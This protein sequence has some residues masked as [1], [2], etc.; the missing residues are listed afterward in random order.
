MRAR[1]IVGVAA[2][3]GVAALAVS[4]RGDGRQPAPLGPYRADWGPRYDPS[5]NRTAPLVRTGRTLDVTVRDGRCLTSDGRPE[6][7]IRGR[8]SH[9]AIRE[10]RDAV[11]IAVIMR[12][13]K[14]PDGDACLGVGGDFDYRVHLP[15]PVGRRAVVA[16]RVYDAP[17]TPIVYPALDPAVQHRLERHYLAPAARYECS[18]TPPEGLQMKY[19]SKRSDRHSL[20]RAAAS[21]VPR[22]ARSTVYRACLEGLDRA[23]R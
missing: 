14:R 7:S 11:V 5:T 2:L 16:D 9:I 18:E 4:L 22:G 6:G 21:D 23:H 20:A 19:A 12:P 3:L 8:F 10:R 13:E 1:G 15:H 17:E